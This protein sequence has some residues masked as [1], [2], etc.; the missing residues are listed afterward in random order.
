MNDAK[1]KKLFRA[2][3]LKT[4]P[5]PP[6]GFSRTIVASIQRE[7]REPSAISI[8]DLLNPLF[9]KVAAA[10]LII[11]GA[12]LA[13]DL[14]MAGKDSSLSTGFVQITEQWLFATN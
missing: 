13:S 8:F 3:Q 5:E 10:S 2:A 7:T 12:C 9:P 6:F 11:V 14:L 4:A 1:I